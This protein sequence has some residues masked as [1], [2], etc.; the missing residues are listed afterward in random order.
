MN[1]EAVLV[2]K[3]DEGRIGIITLN[4]PEA[5]NTF[6]YALSKD[7]IRALLDLDEDKE[8][9]VIIIAGS[10]RGFSAGIDVGDPDAFDA[11][12]PA[13][14]YEWI[15]LME[16][17]GITISKMKKPVIA[18]VYGFAVANGVGLVASCDLAIAEEGT[19]FGATAINVGLNCIGPQVALYRNIGK[20]KT[21]ELV[22]TGNMILA[23]EAE[24]IGLIN[25]VVAKGKLEAE[26]MSLAK[27]MAAKSPLALQSAKRSFYDMADLEYDKAM[28]LVNNQFA[29]LC[30]LEDTH[31]G[32]RA[33]NEKREPAAWKMK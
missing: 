20:K 7:L 31:E 2:E 10:G 4:R 23:D 16:K 33:F 15:T 5:L 24:R 9:R 19:K 32:V 18:S 26:T 25:K 21:L 1:Y 17:P 3:K 14:Y 13:E 6:N 29:L 12:T 22:L 27:A 30:T 11:M 8:V 28:E